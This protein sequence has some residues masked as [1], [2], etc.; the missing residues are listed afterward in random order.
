[1][2]TAAMPAFLA[3]LGAGSTYLGLIEGLADGLSSFVKLFSGLWSDRLPRRKPLLVAG[4]LVTAAGMEALRSQTAGG[5]CCWDVWADGSAAARGARP[6]RSPG[7]GRHGRYRTAGPSASSGQ[8]IAR[9]R[10]SA[11]FLRWRSW[12]VSGFAGCSS[13]RCCPGCVPSLR[14]CTS[15]ARPHASAPARA[16]LGKR[17]LPASFKKYLVGVGIAGIGDFSN[18]LL[19][20]WATQAFMPRLRSCAGS[21]PGDAALRGLQRGLHRVMLCQRPA[22]RP[23]P[24]APGPRSATVSQSS[25]RS[26]S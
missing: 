2:A 19:I 1:M 8:W 22:G 24:Q 5:T 20:L 9:G 23:I 25:L 14:S 7:R 11:L 16:P 17:A 4:Y 12:R 18:T 10:S 3:T 21:P 13:A 26:R 6:Q 15:C